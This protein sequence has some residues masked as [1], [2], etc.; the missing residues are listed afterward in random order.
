V[1]DAAPRHA[2][3]MAPALWFVR[4]TEAAL[5]SSVRHCARW[6]PV[7]GRAPHERR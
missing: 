3:D 7:S 5:L 6:R 4:M 2:I 1:R